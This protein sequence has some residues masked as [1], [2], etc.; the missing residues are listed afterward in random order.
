MFMRI[1]GRVA[2]GLAGIVLFVPA[3]LYGASEWALRQGH[4]VPLAT[5]KVPHDAAAIEEGGRLAR[6][7]GC[8]G[9]HGADGGGHVLV[10][11]PML[12]RLAPPALARVAARDSDA[13]LDRTIQHGVNKAGNTL[14][15]M[16]TR[17]HRFLA[18]EDR[19]R[20]IAWIRSLKPRQDDVVATTSYGPVGRALILAGKLPPS[21]DPVTVSP[22]TRPADVGRYFVNVSCAACHKL[23]EPQPTE[24]GKQVAPALAP[25]AAAYDP[26]AFRTLLRTGVGMSGR[27]LGLMKNVARGDLHVLTDSE[28]VAIQ[29]YLTGE[30]A[31]MPPE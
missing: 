22:A 20:I 30:A 29:A 11:D 18:D 28:I 25:I 2:I 17:A 1:L 14:F 24:D 12:G 9:C 6:I 4:D 15:V 26:V 19:A 27:D 3:V 16:P 31:R 21:A 8:R 13:E 7:T 10:D 5:I 23:Y